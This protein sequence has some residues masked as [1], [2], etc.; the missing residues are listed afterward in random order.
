MMALRD[1][2]TS[3]INYKGYIGHFYFDEKTS[4]F[5]GRVANT[6]DLITFQG[7]SVASTRQAFQDAVDDYIKW[8]QRYRKEPDKALP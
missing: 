2:D 5:L 4:L 3:M 1:Q 7:T 8:R 6:N